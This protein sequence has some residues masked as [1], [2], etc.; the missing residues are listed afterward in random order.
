MSN[1]TIIPM[2]IRLT[3]TLVLVGLVLLQYSKILKP[4]K[5]NTNT[6]PYP[7]L[8]IKENKSL[9]ISQI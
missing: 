2:D 4:N 5:W 1:T 9:W 3:I 6:R 7:E 8:F